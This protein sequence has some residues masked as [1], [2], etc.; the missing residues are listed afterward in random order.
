MLQIPK[1]TNLFT[2][3]MDN[4]SLYMVWG[5]IGVGKTSFSLQLSKKYLDQSQKVFYINTKF[6]STI[7]LLKRLISPGQEIKSR[8]FVLWNVK[9]IQELLRIV[10]DWQIQIQK[11]V[12]KKLGD[13]NAKFTGF[14]M[15][16]MEAMSE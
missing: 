14:L 15:M 3:I 7:P 1:N 11:E 9:T 10:F 6:T 16:G 12:D 13:D 5:E 4:P 8:D 2:Y